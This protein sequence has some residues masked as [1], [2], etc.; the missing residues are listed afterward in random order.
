TGERGTDK[1]AGEY[2]SWLAPPETADTV[3]SLVAQ[4]LRERGDWDRLRLVNVRPEQ[5]LHVALPQ[6][7]AAVAQHVR[8]SPRPA[9]RIAVQPLEQYLAGL[10][11][12]NF[13]HRCRRA[14]R[15]G[16]EAGVQLV[17]VTHPD[18]ARGLFSVLAKLHQRR[19]VERGQPGAFDSPVFRGFHDEL[20]PAYVADGTGW[21]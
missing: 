10:A 16:A 9:F 17:T 2:L 20:M 19:W 15:A 3:T 18:E 21:L 4:V 6:A 12:G 14:L 11:S 5:G 8:V 7:L 1:I 13:R